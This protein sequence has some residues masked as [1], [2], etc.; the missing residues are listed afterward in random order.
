MWL[1]GE[2]HLGA[3]CNGPSVVAIASEPRVSIW[4]RWVTSAGS[5][6][7]VLPPWQKD[8]VVALVW[9]WPGNSKIEDEES[10]RVELMWPAVEM[11][12][13]GYGIATGAGRVLMGRPLTL[14]CRSRFTE[15]YGCSYHQIPL[16]GGIQVHPTRWGSWFVKRR[17]LSIWDMLSR[18]TPP[19]PPL[20]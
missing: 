6:T 13:R 9:S 8:M 11:E 7:E 4:D 10:G 2:C 14:L 17:A 18:Q 16:S 1:V 20:T 19:P 5:R 15:G 12:R 3:G